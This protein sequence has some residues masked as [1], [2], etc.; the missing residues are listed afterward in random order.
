MKPLAEIVEKY[1]VPTGIIGTVSGFFGFF[2]Q[3][4][5]QISSVA[6]AV[7]AVF[8]AATAIITFALV[9]RQWRSKR[10]RD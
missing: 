7:G 9:I 8:G 2:S 4:A 10:R 1:P 3:H 6:S 5:D